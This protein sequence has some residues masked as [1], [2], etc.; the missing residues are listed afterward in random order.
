MVLDTFVWI[1]F[2]KFYLPGKSLS[3][4]KMI[5]RCWK[6]LHDSFVCRTIFAAM[7]D[8]ILS[9]RDWFFFSFISKWINSIQFWNSF[10]LIRSHCS[11]I[12][13]ARV[14][15][16]ESDGT[17]EKPKKSEWRVKSKCLLK[18]CQSGQF[19]LIYVCFSRTIC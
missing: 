16:P 3:H 7:K 10:S 4:Y 19:I 1:S 5:N 14:K 18:W 13:D 12:R 17:I 15:I 8:V 9:L 11:R 2:R 6:H